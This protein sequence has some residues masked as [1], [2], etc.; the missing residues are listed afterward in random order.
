MARRRV[1]DRTRSCP[2]ASVRT[3]LAETQRQAGSCPL[4]FVW[5]GER[6]TVFVADLLGAG[7]IGFNLGRGEYYPPRPGESFLLPEGVLQPNA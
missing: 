7:G 3:T 5:D 6:V 1:A 2:S 4:L